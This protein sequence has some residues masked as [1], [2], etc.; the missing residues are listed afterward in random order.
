MARTK[1]AC[2]QPA[3]AGKIAK[4]SSEDVD[5]KKHDADGSMS[6]ASTKAS[7][8]F[9]METP[10]MKGGDVTI[11]QLMQ[12]EGISFKEAVGVA[13][14]LREETDAFHAAHWEE[15]GDPE[16]EPTKPSKR[17]R[18]PVVAEADDG[19]VV[20]AGGSS[21]SKARK[22]EA[23]KAVKHKALPS[24]AKPSTRVDKDTASKGKDTT[25]KDKD[26]T[27]NDKDT[28]S[29]AKDTASKA[30][31]TASK[32]GDTKDTT[33]KTKDTTSK[34]K[35]TTSKAC[36]DTPGAIKLASPCVV[37]AAVKTSSSAADEIAEP[38]PKLVAFWDKYKVSNKPVVEDT[39]AETVP[40]PSLDA[41]QEAEPR[42]RRGRATSD[43]NE[44]L[45][46][47]DEEG[48]FIPPAAVRRGWS[49]GTLLVADQQLSKQ[50]GTI[51][52]AETI[53]PENASQILAGQLDVIVCRLY[54]SELEGKLKATGQAVP[55]MPAAVKAEASSG[56]D[57]AALAPAEED[58]DMEVD[59]E[60]IGGSHAEDNDCEAREGSDDE[61][62]ADDLVDGEEAASMGED[63]NEEAEKE[64]PVASRPA[65]KPEETEKKATTAAPTI[66]PREKN[67]Q[68]S[69]VPI[70]G[71]ACETLTSSPEPSRVPSPM[72]PP[73]EDVVNSRTH[74]REYMVLDRLI[75]SGTL[76]TK[77][78][79]MTTLAEGTLKDRQEL[80][81]RW[82]QTG[83]NVSATEASL[84]A[85][86]TSRS[87]ARTV[88]RLVPV[89]DMTEAPYRFSKPRMLIYEMQ[90]VL[91]DVEHV[92]MR[93]KIEAIIARGGGIT[94]PDAPGVLAETRFWVTH[95]VESADEVDVEVAQRLKVNCEASGAMVDGILGSDPH[96]SGFMGRG[97]ASAA[98]PG[99]NM[100]VLRAFDQY[101]NDLAAAASVSA[102]LP[103]PQNPKTPKPSTLNPKPPN[104]KPQSLNFTTV[105]LARF[106]CAR[107][108]SIGS[109]VLERW[110]HQ[111]GWW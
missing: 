1:G 87:R 22:A 63:E 85:S 109:W 2:E 77:C 56:A 18:V 60:S 111:Q 81:K 46:P 5:A 83:G 21:G 32:A 37:S 58:A 34:A 16:P 59:G 31:D 108:C 80:L 106:C 13:M 64:K 88:K 17:T 57:V 71:P 103:K 91:L 101:N 102:G 92:A 3:R 79:N 12:D 89:K 53:V 49:C 4:T 74:K 25:S 86:R 84:E 76:A 8:C 82:V 26:T 70:F 44:S 66:P 107:C 27:S 48:A 51:D 90:N 35:D 47:E 28:T 55:A 104:P 40:E 54:Q 52:A 50:R 10:L 100:D 75:K 105:S 95:M 29:K 98:A 62:P 97:K 23:E 45:K 65:G 24:K 99:L 11:G 36:K 14:R 61:E 93:Q 42:L 7:S 43:F 72:P 78:P 38:S 20:G 96:N 110:S 94:D 39:M 33:S 19:D 73:S 9:R 67:A 68:P 6:E 69:S 15:R 41:S 30:K